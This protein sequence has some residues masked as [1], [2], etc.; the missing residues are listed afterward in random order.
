MAQVSVKRTSR[1]GLLTWAY[2]IGLVILGFLVYIGLETVAPPPESVDPNLVH[3][4]V[5]VLP[6]DALPL[7]LA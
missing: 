3:L 7:G 1:L 5:H 2:I 4:A 6:G